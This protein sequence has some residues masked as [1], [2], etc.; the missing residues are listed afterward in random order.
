[1]NRWMNE[2]SRSIN[3][4]Y[5]L[6]MEENDCSYRWKDRNEVEDM[7]RRGEEWNGRGMDGIRWNGM[8]VDG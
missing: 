3:L 8:G 1:M 2:Y 6:R 7:Y 5:W 4:T